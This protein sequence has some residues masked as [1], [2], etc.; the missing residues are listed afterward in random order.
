MNDRVVIPRVNRLLTVAILAFAL[1]PAAAFATTYLPGQTLN[2]SCLPTDSTCIVAAVPITTGSILFGNGTA[3]AATSSSLFWDSVNHRLGIGT[4]SPTAILTL[5][6]SSPSGTIMRVSNSSVGGHIYDWLST[7]SANTGGA[8]RLDLFDYTAGAARLSIA[9]N[10]NVGIGST[11]P[12]SILSVAGVA[13]WTT[14][15]STYYSTG[16]INLTGGCFAIAGNCLSHSNLGGIVSIANGGTGTTTWQTNSIPYFNG[17]TFTESNAIFN[18]N[19]TTFATPLFAASQGSGT[20]TIASGQGFAIGSS[21]FV[22]QQGSGNVGIGT[23]S[24][25]YSL[26]VNGFVNTNAASGYKQ[27]GNTIL[28]ANDATTHLL[29]V[30]S[31][32]A[33]SWMSTSTIV[34]EDIAIGYWAMHSTPSAGANYNTAVG[35]YSLYGITSGSN[36]TA[37]G[38]SALN[39]VTSGGAD[40]AVGVNSGHNLT[41]G[42]NNVTIGVSSMYGASQ[43]TST[44]SVGYQAGAGNYSN[45][46][47]QGSTAIGTNAGYSF[48]TGSD[49]N[50][51]LGY[52][53]GYKITTGNNN[54]WVGSATSSTA[55]A[56]LTTGSQNILIGNNI[57]LPSAT[58]S[59]QL[60]I[61]NILYG[62]G[63]T[64]TGSTLSTGNIG[65]GTTNP[66][67]RLQV[68]GPDSGASTTA[69]LVAN[70]ASSTLF[71]V[72][73][74]G[75]AVL[76]GGLTQ[77]SDQRLKT[78]VQSLDASSSLSLIDQLNPVT[79]NWI[80]PNRGSTPQ[81]GFIAQQVL[82][83][84]PNLVSTTSPTALTPDGTLSLNYIDLISPIVSAI[85]ALSSEFSSIETTITG[86]TN[87]F[88][89][90]DLTFTRDLCAQESNGNKICITGDQLAALVANAG[91][92]NSNAPSSD[93]TTATDTP[94]VIQLNGD[95]PAIVQ[96]GATYNDL[97]ATITGPQA[98]LNLGITT[99]LNG[100]L[101]SNIVIDTSQAATDTIDYVA[102]DQNGLTSTSTRAV[103]IEAPVLPPPDPTAPT[104]DAT[105]T[106][107]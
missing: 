57:S 92:G 18:F 56:N 4:T 47:N 1:A 77:T 83:I 102:T 36:D 66:Y 31:P 22:L 19:G 32:D 67:S 104:T 15:T 58:A 52:Q 72:S 65:I 81:L 107:Q 29:A 79:F 95:N 5:D 12:G 103:I 37:L 74:N 84:F 89:T 86:F 20:S 3:T 34:S 97:G 17:T 42:S 106:S 53:A 33:A 105:S 11:T 60:N 46:S 26:D 93:D 61:G 71:Y 44:V 96:V 99:F 2:P 94:P 62:T 21:Q 49:Y 35:D 40:V 48:Q 68:T 98:D 51:L 88:T 55:V 70:S 78:N 87:S 28:F 14:S 16:G 23:A 100:A 63:I 24:P 45:Y 27:S 6:S 80:D 7:G 82:P 69:F 38:A 13:N 90:G 25:G 41:T 10:G 91:H 8:G 64:G 73:D 30:G 50:T 9:S 43:S 54:I 39:A 59:G 75:N 76:Q 85:Q 101:T